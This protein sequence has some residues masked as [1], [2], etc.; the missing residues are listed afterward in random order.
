MNTPG[1][2]GIHVDSNYLTVAVSSVAILTTLGL[3]YRF[4]NNSH[5]ENDLVRGKLRCHC[6]K[7]EAIFCAPKTTPVA[8]C[9]CEDCVAVIDWAKTCKQCNQEVRVNHF[10]TLNRGFTRLFVYP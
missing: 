9:H 6:G 10:Y 4:F 1:I 3:T 8:A 7:V 2:S 5:H